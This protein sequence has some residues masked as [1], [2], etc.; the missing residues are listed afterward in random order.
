METVGIAHKVP[1][2]FAYDHKPLS[3][4]LWEKRRAGKAPTEEFRPV[5]M[6]VCCRGD[7][8]PE[9]TDAAC[10]KPTARRR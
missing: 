3:L 8:V 7:F 10:S 5:D 6:E 9:Y 2:I 1:S 4:Y